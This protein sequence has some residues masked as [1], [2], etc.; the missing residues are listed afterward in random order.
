M[1]RAKPLHLG[2]RFFRA[3]WPRPPRAQ[4]VAWVEGILE[5]DE[6]ALWHELP[7]HDR[8]YSIRVAKHAESHLAGTEYA[9][10]S[11]WL[12]A[13]LLHDVGKLDAGLGVLGRSVATVIGTI[14]GPARVARWTSAPGFRGRAERY[15]RHDERGAERIRAAGGRDEAARWALA[16]HHRDRWPASGVPVAVAEALEAADNA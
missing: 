2:R 10:Q 16:H 5:P 15:L 8:R 3:L 13:A 12:A 11:R 14:A 7:N 1:S 9:G 6:L 4:D